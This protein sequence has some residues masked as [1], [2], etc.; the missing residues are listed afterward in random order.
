MSSIE[1]WDCGTIY[2]TRG[3]EMGMPI[4]RESALRIPAEAAL[5]LSEI[6]LR[7]PAWL[8]E[9][10]HFEIDEAEPCRIGDVMVMAALEFRQDV[11]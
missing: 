11:A 10:Q 1:V 6:G 2:P 7:D 5:L 4:S 3:V 8:L 9:Q